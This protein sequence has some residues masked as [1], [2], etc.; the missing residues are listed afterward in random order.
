MIRFGDLKNFPSFPSKIPSFIAS[1][2]ILIR[3]KALEKYLNDLFKVEN[4]GDSVA[5]R[6]FLNVDAKERGNFIMNVSNV[7]RE[8]EEFLRNSDNLHD[9]S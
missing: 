1:E 3:K 4:I 2:T 5:F 8:N 6:K 7:E 9:N